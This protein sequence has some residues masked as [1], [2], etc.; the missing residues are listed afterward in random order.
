MPH[1]PAPSSADIAELGL[2][3]PLADVLA[4]ATV[5]LDLLT[6]DDARDDGQEKPK[7]RKAPA[8]GIHSYV[9]RLLSRVSAP[10]GVM[11]TLTS[12]SFRRGGAQAA[13][14]CPDLTLQW[15]ADHGGW[16]LSAT[17][18]AFQYIFNTT[19]ED[20]KV[21]KV[22]SGWDSKAIVPVVSFGS[23]DSLT[24]SKLDAVKAGRF[25]CCSGLL[26]DHFNVSPAVTDVWSRHTLSSRNSIPTHQ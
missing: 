14:G 22:L 3:I 10:A 17:N 7:G 1:L 20:Q 8:P 25:A 24:R 4:G 21:A 18:K 2:L 5:G 23:F 13:N 26:V 11:A 16:S 15:I 12:H 9:N 6:L 19:Q